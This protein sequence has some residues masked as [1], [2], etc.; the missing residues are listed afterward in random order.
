MGQMLLPRLTKTNHENWGIQMKALLGSQ[1]AWEVVEEGFEEQKD[2]TGY[3][4][5]QNKVL[6]EVWSKDKVALYML[7]WAVDES[8]F[9]KIARA[10]T[11]KE[12]W[13]TLGTV[14]KGTDRVKEVCLQTLRSELESMKVK[15]SENIFEYITRVQTVVNQLNRNGEMLAETRVVE[16]ILRSLTN[17]FE[18]VVCVIEESKALATFTVDELVGS[19]E[20][21]D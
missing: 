15:Q 4:A 13:D 12:A 9:E 2:T 18:N 5:T 20:A 7:F 16:K 19:L 21:H 6:K 8:G 1:D 11:S 3:T 14:F 10:T 17:N